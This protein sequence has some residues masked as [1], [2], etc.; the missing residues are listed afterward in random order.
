[1]M[2][3][4][5]SLLAAHAAHLLA[6]AILAGAAAPVSAQ[7]F[8][9][10]VTALRPEA[11]ARGVSKATFDAAFKGVTPDLSLPDLDRGGGEQ[12]K[13]DNRGQAEFTRPPSQYLDKAYL[14]KLGNQGRKLLAAHKNDLDIIEQRIGVD[15][16]SLLA[17]WGRETAYGSY[18]PPHDVIRVLATQAY[19]GRR[20]DFFRNELL[21]ALEM[22][23]EGVP[24]AS[25]RSSWAGAMGLTQFMPSE[26]KP[27]AQDIDG[28]G[29]KDIFKSEAD[30]LGSTAAQ[31]A[32]KGWVRGET[33]GYEVAIP[34]GADCAYEGP[35]QERTIG[36]WAKLGF[37]RVGERPWT[38]K[39]L[40]QNAYLMSPAGAYG[41]AF[42]V[43]ENFKVIRKYNTTDLYAVFVGHLADRI[44][45]GADFVTPW[46]G[47]LPQK[48]AVVEEIQQRL[49]AAGY[50]VDKIDGRIGSNTRRNVG[51]YQRQAKLKVDCWPSDSVLA[52]L[53]SSVPAKSAASP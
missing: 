44:S 17:F 13:A 33:W 53:R 22:L 7:S 45:G 49:K 15:R 25:M 11:E 4:I 34:E 46:S 35:T 3:A 37:K 8:Q 1:M 38:E 48:T 6:A 20:K 27:Y 43:L 5:R 26:Y 31:L 28:D 23:Q 51:Q 42:L 2:T 36:E 16:Y 12:Q 19:A 39:H 50:E 24:R 10:F 14:E 9:E 21:C 47:S 41:P 52:H 29:K 40:A 18:N 32:G 30:A